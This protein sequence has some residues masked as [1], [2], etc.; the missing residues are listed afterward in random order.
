MTDTRRPFS[1]EDLH[2]HQKI[3]STTCLLDGSLAIC[4]VRSVDRNGDKYVSRLWAF[5]PAADSILQLTSGTATDSSPKLAPSGDRVAFISNRTG[6]TQIH[7]LD[8]AGGEARQLGSFDTGVSSAEWCADGG[9]LLVTAAVKVD[10]DQR[11]RRSQ[12]PPEERKS[13]PQVAWRL[14]YKADGMGYLLASETHLFRVDAATGKTR[15]LTDGDFNVYTA[16]QSPDGASIAYTRTRSGVFAH[17]SDL[18]ICDADGGGH[19]QLTWDLAS[20]I[21]PVWSPDE[22]P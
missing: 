19:R 1:V 12:T 20:A 7:L 9:S 3:T 2:L 10:P 4:S 8:L 22:A 16:R 5:R 13:K 18:W 21:D 6:S 11:G 17:R 14:P 15:R